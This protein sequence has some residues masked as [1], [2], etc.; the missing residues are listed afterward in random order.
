MKSRAVI[1]TGTRYWERIYELCSVSTLNVGVRRKGRGGLET[2][3]VTVRPA[4]ANRELLEVNKTVPDRMFSEM[5]IVILSKS[6]N[7]AD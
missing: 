2:T 3:T 5:A 1:A 6:A 7:S 4:N